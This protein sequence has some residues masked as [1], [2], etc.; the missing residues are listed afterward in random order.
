MRGMRRT[1]EQPFI[2]RLAAKM[3]RPEGNE[4]RSAATIHAVNVDSSAIVGVIGKMMEST[5]IE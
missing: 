5:E 3:L 2:S 1:S 4:F